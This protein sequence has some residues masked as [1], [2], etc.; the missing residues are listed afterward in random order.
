M[1][2][3][4]LHLKILSFLFFFLLVQSTTTFS[5]MNEDSVINLA[6]AFRGLTKDDITISVNFDKEKSPRNDSKLFLP[7][8]KK[9]MT[10]PMNYEKF[11]ED[12]SMLSFRKEEEIIKHFYDLLDVR[13]NPESYISQNEKITGNDLVNICKRFKKFNDTLTRIFSKE[14]K[15]FLTKNI[16]SLVINTAESDESNMDIFKFNKSRDSGNAVSKRTLDLLS[17][18]NMQLVMKNSLDAFVSCLKVYE[19]V[20]SSGYIEN[21]VSE[22]PEYG[23]NEFIFYYEKEGIRIAIGGYEKNVYEGY[24]DFI[25]DFGGD[26]VY[27]VTASQSTSVSGLTCIMDLSGNDYYYT[28]T[29]FTLAGS[30]FGAGM[31]F[32]KSGEDVYKGKN[33]S[34]G[35]S[36]VGLGFLCDEDGN[37]IYNAG[38]FSQAAASF[39]IGILLD[40]NGNDFYI[41]NSYSQGF[42]MTQGAGAI[43]DLKGNDSYLCDARA[44]DIGRY[45]DHFISMCQ[46]FGFGMR[47]YY[48]GG[49]GII[50]EGEGNDFYSSD[51]YGQGSAY[52]YGIGCISDNSGND[53]YNSYQYSQGAGI[54]LAV[55][56]LK[57][58]TGWDYYTSNGVSQG[59]GHDFGI[60]ILEDIRGNDN[61]SAYSLSQGAGNANGIGILFDRNGSDGY[62]NKE[63]GNSREYGNPRRDFG[64]LGLF[65]DFSGTDYYSEPGND[66][67]IANTSYWGTMM[68]FHLMDISNNEISKTFKIPVDSSRDYTKEEF[69]V[70]AKTIEPRFSLW[71]EYGF[72]KLVNDSNKTADFILNFLD[73][74]DHR[75]ALV[76]RN[77]AFKIGYTLGKLFSEKLK[78]HLVNMHLRQEFNEN[79]ISY[80]CYLF[81]ETGN[82]EGREELL[83]LT[84]D[85]NIKIKTSSVNALGKIKLTEADREF[86]ERVSSRLRELAFSDSEN[87]L[88]NKDISFAFKNYISKENIPALIHLLSNGYFGARFNAAESLKKYGNDYADFADNILDDNILFEMPFIISFAESFK[89]LPELQFKKLFEQIYEM[90]RNGNDPLKLKLIE[91]L[92]HKQSQSEDSGFKEWSKTYLRTL[93]VTGFKKVK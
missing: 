44:L 51:I 28:D 70:M 21:S 69:F 71:Q 50:L 90:A 93:E 55:G 22:N 78:F 35:S 77:L 26:D 66:S 9:L 16:L 29:D 76:L 62:L 7:V 25:L 75:E 45:E 80:I 72:R 17:R 88:L 67:V 57:D 37:D 27:N 39:G 36:V 56:I 83:Q 47:P 86:K 63:P 49:I 41:S 79:Q 6:L 5:Q 11:T 24:Y 73:T 82:P 18:L 42:G 89:E 87:E 65:I 20:K 12:I 85:D 14:E 81:G 52:W 13:F 8:V 48:A 34:L 33:G 61:F 15:D 64:S 40:K 30:M 60:G 3:K 46:G 84:Y 4:F 59:C 10:A 54:H 43:I 74:D 58:K 19:N 1:K 53:K 68:D 92:Q 91:I 38:I 23:S 31:I 32:D 2:F